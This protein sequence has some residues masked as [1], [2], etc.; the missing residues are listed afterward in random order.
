MKKKIFRL[1]KV[2]ISISLSCGL[3]KLLRPEPY[4]P[5]KQWKTQ[6]YLKIKVKTRNTLN[7]IDTS[8]H[9]SGV[10]P[11]GSWEVGAATRRHQKAGL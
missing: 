5:S 3:L 1:C 4:S 8:A 11:G 9:E 6:Y 10:C 2:A 7:D